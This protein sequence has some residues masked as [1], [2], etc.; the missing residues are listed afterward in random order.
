MPESSREKSTPS[1]ET[2]LDLK[3]GLDKRDLSEAIADIA[4]ARDSM[5]PGQ[6][7]EFLS[8]VNKTIDKN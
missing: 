4:R 7:N 3:E 6:Y 2:A 1:E 5:K 8:D